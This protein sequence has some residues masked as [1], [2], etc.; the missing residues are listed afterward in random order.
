MDENK[1]EKRFDIFF[2]LSVLFF[3]VVGIFIV[4]GIL[5]Y[6]DTNKNAKAVYD[7]EYSRVHDDV[8]DEFNELGY[9]TAEQHYHI[10]NRAAVT[11]KE[12]KEIARLEVLDV[13]DTQFVIAEAKDNK[14]KINA[15]LEVHGGGVYTVDLLSGEYIIDTERNSVTVR[16]PEP[17]LENVDINRNETKILLFER[18]GFRDLSY[19]EGEQLYDEQIKEGYIKIRDELSSSPY[20]IESAKNSAEK[21]ITSLVKEVNKDIPDL[22]VYVEFM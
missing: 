9:N 6:A 13:Y 8:Y 20:Y 19:R 1:N 14:D 12:V 2:I 18:N 5:I 22:K 4:S 7:E 16:I 11:I 10:Q 21:L 17:V 3:I 15:W